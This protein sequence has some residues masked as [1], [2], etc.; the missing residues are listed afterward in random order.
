[1]WLIND[2]FYAGSTRKIFKQYPSLFPIKKA[3]LLVENKDNQKQEEIL[4]EYDEKRI[5]EIKEKLKSMIQL[6]DKGEF[7]KR[8]LLSISQDCRWCDYREY[9]EQKDMEEFLKP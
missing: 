2:L 7:P 5:E 6:V 1:M 3:I 8:E 9:C 4:I